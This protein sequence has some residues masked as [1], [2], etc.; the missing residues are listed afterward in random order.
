MIIRPAAYH[1]RDRIIQLLTQ[2][3]VFSEREIRVAMQVFDDAFGQPEREEYLFFCACNGR[4]E[5]LGYICF[6]PITVT[7]D[8]YDLYWIAVDERF[9]R[10][11]IGEK[12]LAFMEEEIAEKGA[13][14]VYIETSSTAPYETARSFYEKHH[15][16]L[17]CVLAD[18]YRE[19][20][21][22][23]IYMKEVRTDVSHRAEIEL[24]GD[25][26]QRN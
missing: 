26:S 18:F 20:D 2:R 14:R 25:D 10:R 13:R 5:L 16:G 1:D 23:M 21:H 6:G 9:S 19:G 22:K 3:G 24:A 15:Y 8:C 17:V 11:R 7:D 12:L 4:D